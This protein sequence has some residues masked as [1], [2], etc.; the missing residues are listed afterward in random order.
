MISWESILSVFNTK[1]TLLKWL[2]KLEKALKDG[3]LLSVAVNTVSEG[4]ITLTFNFA[5]GSTITTP[6]ID[7]PK[8]PQGPQG[9]PGTNG[10]DGTDGTNGRDALVQTRA[11][12]SANITSP[13]AIPIDALNRTAVVGEPIVMFAT[14]TTENKT[15]MLIGTVTDVGSSD[16]NP[17]TFVTFSNKIDIT[18]MTGPA[19]T[20]GAEGPQ[21]PQGETGA[22]GPQGPQGETG[23]AGADLF[24]DFN[25]LKIDTTDATVTYINGVA[26]ITNARLIGYKSGGNEEVEIAVDIPIVAGDNVTVDASVDDKFIQISATGGGETLFKGYSGNIFTNQ[27]FG[28]RVSAIHFDGSVTTIEA[29]SNIAVVDVVRLIIAGELTGT[30]PRWNTPTEDSEGGGYNITYLGKG[31][32]DYTCARDATGS[33]YFEAVPTGDGF[34]FGAIAD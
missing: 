20:P 34:Q 31:W 7:L 5:D 17:Y 32:S 11:L 15:Y 2:Q 4:V 22:E 29:D 3:V 1:G 8:G 9:I 13:M 23:P 24:S 28:V 10:T 26:T 16:V 21:G 27:S 33:V 25:S 18:G 12:S 19:G 6:Q 14:D 30:N